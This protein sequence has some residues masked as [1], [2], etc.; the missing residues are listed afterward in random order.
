MLRDVKKSYNIRETMFD[1]TTIYYLNKICSFYKVLYV[2]TPNGHYQTWINKKERQSNMFNKQCYEKY[3]FVT[4]TFTTV[5][6]TTLSLSLSLSLSLYIYIYIYIYIH[7]YISQPNLLL[8]V[9][10]KGF[11]YSF[12]LWQHVWYSIKSVLKFYFRII[13]KFVKV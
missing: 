6:S 3:L 10:C 9:L 7:I 12:L 8:I 1:T 13:T 4:T 5:I 2:S 11:V